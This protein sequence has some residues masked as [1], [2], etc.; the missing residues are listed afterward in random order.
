MKLALLGTIA[1]I[2]CAALLPV[3]ASAATCERACLEG[4]VNRYMAALIAHDPSGLPF[5]NDVIFAENNNRLKIGEGSWQTIDGL[6][7]YKHYMADPEGGQVGF[8]GTVT[9]FGIPAFMDVRLRIAGGKIAEVESYV[10]RDEG[11]AHRYDEMGEPEAP[12][13]AAVP[14]AQRLS[15]AQL[16][17]TVNKYFESMAHNDGHGDYSFFHPQCNR[18]E[19][20]LKTTNVRDN[21]AYGHSTDTQFASLTCEQ[22]WKTG[23]LGFV[24]RMRDRRFPVI[25]EERQVVFASVGV[26]MNSPTRAIPET[27]GKPFVLPNFFDVPRTQQV[28]EAFKIRDGKLYRIEMTMIE[29]PYAQPLAV[30]I[31]SMTH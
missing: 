21:S 10:M 30:P 14:P 17:E 25:D 4:M 7:K 23:F 15:R 24:T 20:A 22:Q 13:L 19:H 5:A 6:G 18:I 16:V 12:W 28:Q 2:L 1:T 29:V 31:S 26:D 9:E 27:T 8:I 11:A 3:S